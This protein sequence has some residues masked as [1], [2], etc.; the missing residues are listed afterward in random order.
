MSTAQELEI[1]FQAQLDQRRPQVR[2]EHNAHNR[3]PSAPCAEEAVSQDS[4][5]SISKVE[6]HVVSNIFEDALDFP[7]LP[8]LSM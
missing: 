2:Q 8:R 7:L 5:L 4:L 3:L 6:L 1:R